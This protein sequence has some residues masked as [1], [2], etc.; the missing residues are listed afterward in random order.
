MKQLKQT[1]KVVGL[2]KIA[3]DKEIGTLGEELNIYDISSSPIHVGDVIIE[4]YGELKFSP[5]L[6]ADPYM[7]NKF[8]INSHEKMPLI[9]DKDGFYGYEYDT[10]N[11]KSIMYY[12][13]LKP[14]DELV[15][16]EKWAFW[17]NSGYNSV[18]QSFLELVDD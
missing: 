8:A 1:N 2:A 16:G 18:D 9:K 7:A 5:L 3:F 10:Y 4:F 6:C 17:A 11:G 14:Y 13:I 15:V 12:Y